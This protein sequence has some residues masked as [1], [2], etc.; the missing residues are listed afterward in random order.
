MKRIIKISCLLI[1]FPI[2]LIGQVN[3]SQYNLEEILEM[4]LKHAIQLK[5]Y[6]SE[7]KEQYLNN[8]FFEEGLKPQ[9]FAS[10][11]LPNI[12]R[13]IQSRPLPDGRDVFVNTSNMYNSLGLRMDYQLNNG[14]KLYAFSGISRLDIL[15]TEQLP[16]SQNYFFTPISIGIGHTFL[17]FNE[18]RWQKEEYQL[19]QEELNAKYFHVREEVIQQALQKY[20]STFMAQLKLELETQNQ[21]ELNELYKVKQQLFEI[22]QIS[23]TE[24]LRLELELEKNA[25]SFEE[26][27]LNWNQN[28]VDLCDFIGL[29][30]TLLQKVAPPYSKNI[31]INPEKALELITQNKYRALQIK[32]EMNDLE[33]DLMRAKR[34][35]QFTVEVNAS[36]GFNNSGSNLSRIYQDLLNQQNLS[37]SLLL[38]LSS[39]KSN[40]LNQEIVQE[41][42][43]RTLLNIEQ[44]NVD[45]A[46][47]IL[48]NVGSFNLLLRNINSAERTVKISKDIF[49]LSRQ[50]Y[51]IGNKNITEI[52]IARKDREQAILNYYQLI[53]D[54]KIK[55]FEIRRSCLYDFENDQ[56]LIK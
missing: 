52:N 1:F 34:N 24:I 39:H 19:Q 10:A 47:E 5:R 11:I 14:A 46:R 22:G 51:L 56:S 38:P 26:A 17:K 43:H 13:S 20:A 23:K 49:E 35:N 2:F 45:L 12:S 4:A 55:Y 53:L 36:L 28:K 40:A 32:N 37:V 33:A 3:P 25:R 18:I 41:R 29:K 44:E 21:E 15:K 9:F 48:A 54:A 27:T 7:L 6:H 8:N 16:P 30:P 50:Q 31:V 42:L